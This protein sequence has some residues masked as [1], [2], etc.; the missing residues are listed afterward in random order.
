MLL[1]HVYVCNMY[2]LNVATNKSVPHLSSEE[3]ESTCH[4]LFDQLLLVLL[5]VMINFMDQPIFSDLHASILKGCVKLNIL[6]SLLFIHNFRI[7]SIFFVCFWWWFWGGWIWNPALV[8][9]LPS[10]SGLCSA[11]Y[12][13][14]T[15]TAI[16]CRNVI[17]NFGKT[18]AMQTSS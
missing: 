3:N 17:F 15:N 1:H 6:V 2:I 13:Q 4:S 16:L 11:L 8:S 18:H 9:D 7:I 12:P 14:I 10:C 5:I